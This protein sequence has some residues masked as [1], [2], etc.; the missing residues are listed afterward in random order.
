MTTTPN[1]STL[2]DLVNRV[3]YRTDQENSTFVSYTELEQYIQESYFELYDLIIESEGP[4][5][6]WESYYFNTVANQTLYNLVDSEGANGQPLNIYKLIGVAVD[7]AGDGKYRPIRQFTYPQRGRFADATSGW[8]THRSV[9]YRMGT[10]IDRDADV[11]GG[12]QYRTIT[13]KPTPTGVHSVELLYIPTPIELKDTATEEFF[14]HY[15]HWDEYIVV[16]VA[17]K[18]LEKEESEADHLYRRKEELR[19]RILWHANTMNLDDAGAVN[20]VVSNFSERGPYRGEP[21][22]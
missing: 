2:T 1:T 18:V 9:Y 19:Q 5:H 8:S 12:K 20:D 4:T 16:D 13:L 14:L 6:Y 7:V 21:F 10:Q 3:R 22:A 15:A 17:A 11:A